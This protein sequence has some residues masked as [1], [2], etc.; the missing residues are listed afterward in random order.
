MAEVFSIASVVLELGKST[1]RLSDL[2]RDVRR[3]PREIQE[4][5]EEAH[6]ISELLVQLENCGLI[7]APAH[8]PAIQMCL[9]L[10]KKANKHV[11]A[12]VSELEHGL[13][14]HRLLARVAFV[15]K[16]EKLNKLTEKLER[17]KSS[18]LL[19]CSIYGI[20]LSKTQAEAQH[21]LLL[22][23]LSL[24]QTQGLVPMQISQCLPVGQSSTRT[25][26]VQTRV[27]FRSDRA[28]AEPSSTASLH[29]PFSTEY[30]LHRIWEIFTTTATRGW[31]RCFRPYR[32][33]PWDTP[34]FEMCRTGDLLGLQRTLPSGEVSLCDQTVH[35]ATLFTVSRP[36]LLHNF[37]NFL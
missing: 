17:G 19:A 9:S 26:D 28:L 10:C 8:L 5:E 13:E 14:A 36:A 16:K 23:V 35:G 18:L 34:A 1:K 6:G 29:G 3:A 15:L 12:V 25:S 20:W 33:L 21:Q 2:C 37:A 7:N 27:E 30:F 4:F 31:K 32:V 22:D 24:V 11:S